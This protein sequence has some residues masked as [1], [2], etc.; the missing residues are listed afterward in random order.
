MLSVCTELLSFTEL[1]PQLK[2][3]QSEQGKYFFFSRFLHVS[4]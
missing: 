4:D 2:E 3:E 1:S